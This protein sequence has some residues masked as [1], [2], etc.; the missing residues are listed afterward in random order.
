LLDA[1]FA[2]GGFAGRR[3]VGSHIWLLRL[4]LELKPTAGF[5]LRELS[6]YTLA[7]LSSLRGTAVGAI[8]LAGQV[9]E[10]HLTP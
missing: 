8:T 4:R 1:L 9:R 3:F 5:F 7:T 10:K 2:V 6:V